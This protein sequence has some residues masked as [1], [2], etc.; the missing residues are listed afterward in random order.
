MRKILR[1]IPNELREINFGF[2]LWI[3]IACLMMAFLPDS[4]YVYMIVVAV[5]LMCYVLE[6]RIRKL[7]RR[8]KN[9]EDTKNN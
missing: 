6:K 5:A 3:L 9:E 1:G 7:L 2:G 8:Y 4:I